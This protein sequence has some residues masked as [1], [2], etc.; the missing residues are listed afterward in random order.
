MA[1]SRAE[2]IAIGIPVAGKLD[3]G[4][5][6]FLAIADEGEREPAVR[7]VFATQEFHSQHMGIEVDGTLQ[8]AYPQ[9][10]VKKPHGITSRVP[11]LT[12][13]YHFPDPVIPPARQDITRGLRTMPQYC[14][15]PAEIDTVTR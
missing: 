3:H 7:I 2:V 15:T 4:I 6:G 12:L 14:R 11:D 13:R 8:V 5:S 10:G 9:H 1:E